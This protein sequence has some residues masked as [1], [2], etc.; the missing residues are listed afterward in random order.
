M[1]QQSTYIEIELDTGEA[2]SLFRTK[3]C[4][5]R[6]LSGKIWVTE[7][8]GEGDIVLT[9]GDVYRLTRRGRTVVQSVEKRRGATCQLVPGQISCRGLEVL[10]AWVSA[11]AS[12]LI[13]LRR[14]LMF[15]RQPTVAGG[16]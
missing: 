5:L 14:H 6:C 2:V 12:Q 16:H 1:V 15:R 10:R 3:N 13:W 11:F 9:A 8:G 4:V 7:H